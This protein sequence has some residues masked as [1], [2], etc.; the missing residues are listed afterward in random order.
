MWSIYAVA[1]HHKSDRTTCA[2]VIGATLVVLV[3]G[4]GPMT[5]AGFNPARNLGGLV[6]TRSYFFNEYLIGKGGWVFF[7]APFFG[8]GLAAASYEYGLLR[9]IRLQNGIE[10]VED[11]EE[12][13]RQDGV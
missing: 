13:L 8:A 9:L 12:H 5:G 6:M 4:L 2:V 10:G 1:V 3:F 11:Q 7:I